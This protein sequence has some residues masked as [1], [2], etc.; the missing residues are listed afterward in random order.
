MNTLNCEHAFKTRVDHRLKEIIHE[1]QHCEHVEVSTL[2]SVASP[3]NNLWR[4]TVEAA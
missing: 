2:G 4:L 1:C 3:N